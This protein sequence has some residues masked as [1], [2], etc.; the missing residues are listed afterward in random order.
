MPTRAFIAVLAV[1]ASAAQQTVD[2]LAVSI[3]RHAIF[4]SEILDQIRVVA[5]LEDKEP[6]YSRES[7][8]RAA[9][10]L[11]EL[12]LIRR[13]MEVSRFAAPTSKEAVPLLAEFRKSQYADDTK[14][15]EALASRNLRE[16][17]LLGNLLAQLTLTR[18][19]AFRFRPGVRVEQEEIT[20]YYRETFAPEWEKAHTSEPVPPVDEARAEI[21]DRLAEEK[22]DVALDDWLK[23]TRATSRIIYRAEVFE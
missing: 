1:L 21:E 20:E 19:I 14:Y 15:A 11:I 5:F 6:D 13:E 7:R 16:E 10:R 2:R 8:R 17:D 4:E 23:A 3:D 22:V 18:F 12:T 9:D